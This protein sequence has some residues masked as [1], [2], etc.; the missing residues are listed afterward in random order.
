M[1]VYDI[2]GNLIAEL[3]SNVHTDIVSQNPDIKTLILQAKRP[4]NA[5][6]NDYLTNTKPL[7]LMHFS[8]IHQDATRLARIV[9]F[10]NAYENNIDNVICSGDL[11]ERRFSD[12]MSWFDAVDGAEKILLA[13]GNHDA[14]A[15]TSGYDWT[16]LATEANQYAQYMAPYIANWNCT[17]TANTTYYYKDYADKNVRLIVLNCMLTGN[18][19]AAQKTWL[20]STLESARTTGLS[21]VIV[22]H[23]PQHN[24]IRIE[25]S[26]S[27]KDKGGS[28]EGDYDLTNEYMGIVQNFIDAGGEFVCYLCGHLHYDMFTKATAYPNQYCI[29]IDSASVAQSNYYSDTMRTINDKSEDLANLVAID[30]SS[31]AVK[32]IRVGADTD[33]YLRSKKCMTFKYD[34]GTILCDR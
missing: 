5:G 16:N 10:S 25:C 32:V 3:N 24:S 4:A 20:T 27:S 34:T 26:F 9:E 22:E 21:V 13:I 7:V 14:L 15:A 29:G 17:Y 19:D 23:Y 18:D 11:V 1:S 31:K 12:G 2:N 33:H 6:M 8:D 30:T 28:G